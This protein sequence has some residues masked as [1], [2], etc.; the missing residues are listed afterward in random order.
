VDVSKLS[1]MAYANLVH[2]DDREDRTGW[3]PPNRIGYARPRWPPK[4]RE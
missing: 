3:R 4:N 2:P 1:R